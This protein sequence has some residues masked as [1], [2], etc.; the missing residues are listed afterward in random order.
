MARTP[1]GKVKD[2]LKKLLGYH[3]VYYFQPVQSGYGGPA[4]DFICCYKGLYFQIETKTKNNDMTK[5]QQHVAESV[6]QAGGKA[7]LINDNET[8]WNKLETWLQDSD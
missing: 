8:T 6:R 1:E 4:L 3:E 7:F 2:K 5:R